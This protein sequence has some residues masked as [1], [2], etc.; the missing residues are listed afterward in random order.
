MKTVAFMMFGLGLALVMFSGCGGSTAMQLCQ[1]ADDCNALRGQTV[2]DCT[3]NV[4]QNLEDMAPSSRADCEMG[5]QKCLDFQACDGF[6]E[7][8][9]GC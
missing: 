3:A 1:R 5:L 9:P 7:C 2:E 6:L 8:N 4:Q